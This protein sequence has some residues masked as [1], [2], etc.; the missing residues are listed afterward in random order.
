MS[1]NVY[2]EGGGN[3]K[4]LK[5]DCRRGFRKFVEN[6]GLAGK[7]PRIVACGSRNDAFDDFKTAVATGQSALLLV[8]AEGPVTASGPWQ[9]LK[10]RDNWARPEAATEDHCHL[11]VQVMESWFLADMDA[12]EKFYG[13]NFRKVALPQNPK[14]ED[15]PKLDIERGL[16]Q[17]TRNSS[18]GEYSKGKHS[19]EILVE[20][21]PAKVRHKSA[22]AERFLSTLEQLCQQ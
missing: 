7:M 3:S 1:A 17:A 22:Y 11:M 20:L 10:D 15:V 12:L 21:D 16:T 18:K 6:A 14:I 19:F 8:D 2:V 4:S 5:S 9:H 13:D